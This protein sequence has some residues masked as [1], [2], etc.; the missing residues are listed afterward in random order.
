MALQ[1]GSRTEYDAFISYSHAWDRTVAK[2]FQAQAQGFD[3][4]WFKPRSLKVFR[5]ETNLGASP[6]LWPEIEAGLARSR[7]LV[8]MA[9]PRA[10]VSPWV[11]KEIRWWLTH[12]SPDTI[13]IA[14]TDGILVWDTARETFDWS[15]TDALPREE[16]GQVFNQQPRWVDLRWLR[17]SEQVSA[18][19]PR[20]L[21]CVAEFVAPLTGKSK[22]ELIGDHVRQ[23][24]RTVRWVRTTIA[25]LTALAVA[26][27]MASVVALRQRDAARAQTRL[28]TARQLA[29][30]AQSLSADNLGLASLLAVEAY[31]RQRTPETLS[32]LQHVATASPHLVR[33][34]HNDVPVTQLAFSDNGSL[35]AVGDTEGTVS[36]WRNDGKS[37]LRRSRV[38][39]KVT[40]LAFDHGTRMLA[41]GDEEGSVHRLHLREKHSERAG[42]MPTAV[43][44]VAFDDKGRLAAGALDG[45]VSLFQGVRRIATRETQISSALV[46]FRDKGTRLTV[47]SPVGSGS[48]LDV[49]ALNE[50]GEPWGMRAPAGHFAS[51]ASPSGTC[52]GF[53]KRGLVFAEASVPPRN[54]SSSKRDSCGKFPRLPTEEARHFALADSGRLAAGTARGII[55][56]ETETPSPTAEAAEP[57]QVL[58]GVAPPT[59]MV[60]SPGR[61]DRLA[62][63]SG[64]TVALWDL[65]Q[66]SRTA[67]PTGQ[68]VPDSATVI[69]PPPLA[70]LPH[71]DGVAWSFEGD[72]WQDTGPI[73]FWTPN[74]RRPVTGNA[75]DFLYSLAF[76]ADG[77][78]LIAGGSSAVI[79]W[80]V[81][82]ERLAPDDIIKLPTEEDL[83]SGVPSVASGPDGSVIAVTN[84]GAVHVVDP[85]TRRVRTPIP[86]APRNDS[87][88]GLA[89]VLSEDGRIAVIARPAGGLSVRDT[90][91][92]SLHQSVPSTAGRFLSLA[93]ASKS[94]HLFLVGEDES[95]TAWDTDRRQILWRSDNAGAWHVAASTDG[96][97][98]VTLSTDGA[99]TQWDPLTGDKIGRFTVPA[100]DRSL[101]GGADGIGAQ[102]NIMLSPA[103][104]LLWTATEGGRIIKWHMSVEA[105]R[106]TACRTAG[107]DL[108][109]TEWRRYMASSPPEDLDCGRN[110]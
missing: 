87:H 78:K 19:D 30:T 104:D 49:P 68:T 83:G 57:I 89:S 102:T 33:F 106:R 20:L 10:A 98:L 40:A 14:W 12:R 109:K 107:R 39:G 21:E 64:G 94:G 38:R 86:T 28:A 110:S 85:S 48:L 29:A 70:L 26:A 46:S 60:F 101:S 41:V 16:M 47:S 91:T 81:K 103:G 18:A 108:T 100:P 2:A 50:V 56:S 96:Q 45:A 37:V 25:V 1:G 43:T 36:V 80:D 84:L 27:A 58:D 31:R 22:D 71:G 105:W 77:K 13:L 79:L 55:V 63:A 75:D 95:L 92:G 72:G 90:N 61:G 11:R 23:H 3:R 93:L 67:E 44:S 99:V 82:G 17:S 76:T 97:T 74:R 62:S 6:Q 52:F 34:V 54:T 5:D 4:P 24:R 73:R 35:V 53:V 32:A 65:D 69:S 66:V 7:W 88:R 59:V 42:G 9:S 51:S 15:V 8:I